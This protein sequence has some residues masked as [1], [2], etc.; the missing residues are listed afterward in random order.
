MLLQCAILSFSWASG[1]GETRLWLV[2]I[3]CLNM[4]LVSAAEVCV[5]RASSHKVPVCYSLL[6]LTPGS[7]ILSALLHCHAELLVAFS[8]SHLK[9]TEFCKAFFL[10]CLP[11]HFLFYCLVP[12][13]MWLQRDSFSGRLAISPGKCLR[14][15]KIY[16][17]ILCLFVLG[18][19][20]NGGGK[21][22]LGTYSCPYFPLALIFFTF[23]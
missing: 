23:F 3:R 15:L 21:R 16:M 12:Y 7:H 8:H 14:L 6:I 5:A 10:Y 17:N 4:M 9:C 13:W 1:N 2:L 11:W 22:A 19:L 18:F 20:L